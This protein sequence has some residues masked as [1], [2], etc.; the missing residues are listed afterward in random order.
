MA[1]G[2]IRTYRIFSVFTANEFDAA[3]DRDQAEHIAQAEPRLTS[4]VAQIILVTHKR[5]KT[6]RTVELGR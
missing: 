5:P 2:Q 1:L 4:M 3:I 6:D